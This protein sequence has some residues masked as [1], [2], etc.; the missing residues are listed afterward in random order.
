[1]KPYYQDNFITIYKGDCREVCPILEPVDCVVTDPPYG[2]NFMGKGWD[3]GVPGIE[4]W[5]AIKGAM[6][7]GAHLLAFGGTRTFHRLTCAIEDAGFEIRDCVMWL[8]GSG[9]PKS[10][11]VSRAIDKEAGAKREKTTPRGAIGTNKTRIAQGYRKNEVAQSW[12]DAGP[13]TE[14][15]KQWEGWGTALKPAVEPICLARKPISEKTIAANVL[16]YGT[17]ALNIDECRVGTDDNTG[18]PC[19]TK[20]N[21]YGGFDKTLTTET[22]PKGRWPAN[23]IHDGSDEVVEGFPETE[24]SKK[25]LRGLQG[26]TP[27]CGLEGSG[28]KLDTNSIRGHNDNGGSA[29]RFFYTAKASKS[30]R[31]PDNTHPTAKPVALLKYLI[32]LINPPGGKILDPF[33]GSGS[34]LVAAK[35]LGMKAIGIDLDEDGDNCCETAKKRLAQ[36]VFDF[37]GGKTP[38]PSTER[39]PLPSIMA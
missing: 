29:S 24:P 38:A 10:L 26:V 13:I 30:D 3:N 22:N 9:F 4:F 11:D 28:L 14:A 5:E 19:G 16:K 17:G 23:V 6:K 34:T 35:E 36:E 21:V 33:M 12:N 7:P 31:G 25:A 39:H 18:R 2:L 1:M 27:F 15:A 37:A 20:R 8:Y 32:T